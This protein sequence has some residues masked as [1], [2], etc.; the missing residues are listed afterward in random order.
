MKKTLT[1][2]IALCCAIN[3]MAFD[4]EDYRAYAASM[5]EQVWKK[6]ALPEFDN[7]RC[8]PSMKKESA[9][10]LASYDE[11]TID[12][13]KRLRG[14][15]FNLTLYN[16]RQVSPTTTSSAAWL[17]STTSRRWSGSRS[18]TTRPLRKT[19]PTA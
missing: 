10:I 17:P 16:V 11:V 13:R 6:T 19:T 3:L 5:R 4:E 7:H 8:P 2:I 14:N 18:S 12:Q 15:A 1:L 9:V